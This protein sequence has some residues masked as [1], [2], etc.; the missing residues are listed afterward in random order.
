MSI[1]REVD[2][3]SRRE[4]LEVEKAEL[5]VHIGSPL[6]LNHNR[7]V[8]T[9]VERK[10]HQVIYGKRRRQAN[11]ELERVRVNEWRNRNPEK[12]AEQVRRSLEQQREKRRQSK[13]LA[14]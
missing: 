14:E 12:R 1:L 5:L 6:C 9:K 10:E 13:N 4:L 11:A 8:I 7:P 3:D 2:V